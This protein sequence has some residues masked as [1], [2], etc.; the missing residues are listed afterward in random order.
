MLRTGIS[1]QLTAFFMRIS[2]GGEWETA[3]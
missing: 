1:N 2:F 3:S